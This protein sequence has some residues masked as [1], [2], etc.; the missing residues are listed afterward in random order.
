MARKLYRIG[1]GLILVV[2]LTVSIYLLYRE[3]QQEKQ[4]EDGVLVEREQEADEMCDGSAKETDRQER[5]V[6]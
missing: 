1:I 3:R 5:G 4:Y 2:I 6:A